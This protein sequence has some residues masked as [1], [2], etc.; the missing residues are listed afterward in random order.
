MISADDPLVGIGALE[1]CDDVVERFDV[2]IRSYLQM[3]AGRPGADVIGDGEPASPGFRCDGTFKG[4]EQGLRVG[5]GDGKNRD[6]GDGLCVFDV[7]AF[8]AGNGADSGRKRIAGIV[9]VHDAAA[10]HAVRGTPSATGIVVA[11]EEAV[12]TR[13]GIDEASDGAVFGGDFGLYAAPPGAI[14]RDHDRSFDRDTH[15]VEFFVVLTIAIVHVDERRS[16][17]AVGGVGIVGRELFGSLIRRG[18]GGEGWFLQFGAEF[19]GSNEFNDALLRS[20][21][22]DIEILDSGVKPPLLEAGQ[23]PLS[24]V[25]VISRTNVVR[26]RGEAAHVFADIARHYC[27][28]E[29]LFEVPL[30]RGA[31]GRIAEERVGW[32]GVWSGLGGRELAESEKKDVRSE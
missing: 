10:L 19:C 1:G 13:I 2:P 30:S 23:D 18:I 11:M 5:V 21:K 12:A 28:L 32:I 7:E 9:G 16:N 6:L 15:P 22:E 8:G 25:F 29:F 27:V 3:N 26:P 20:G 17:V 24:V 31:A 4:R 14:S